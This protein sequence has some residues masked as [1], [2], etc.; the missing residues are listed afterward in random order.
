MLQY[1][2]TKRPTALE[3]LRHPF[4]CETLDEPGRVENDTADAFE[5]ELREASSAR[6]FA[7]GSTAYNGSSTRST[8]PISET[9]KYAN[10]KP[11][12]RLASSKGKVVAKPEKPRHNNATKKSRMKPGASI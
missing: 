5:A 11:P 1:D 4:V 6:P 7:P 12:K 10:K 8:K 2:Q 9:G 3:A